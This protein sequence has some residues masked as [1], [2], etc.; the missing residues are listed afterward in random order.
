MESSDQ[1]YYFFVRRQNKYKRGEKQRRQTTFGYWKIT[2]HPTEIMRKGG[3]GEKIGEKRVLMF[4]ESEP[5]SKSDWVMHEYIA[6]LMPPTHQ[7]YI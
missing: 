7:V 6:T 3:D 1:V 5:K 2:G 4:Y